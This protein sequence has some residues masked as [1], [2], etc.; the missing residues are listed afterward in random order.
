MVDM[1]V[2]R[3]RVLRGAYVGAG[4]FVAGTAEGMI[5]E[6]FDT[7]D[8]GT[9]LGQVAIGLGGSIA[10]DTVFDNPDSIPNDMVEYAGYGIQGAGFANLGRAIQTGGHAGSNVVRVE[11]ESGMDQTG[12]EPEQEQDFMADV[13]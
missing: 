6:R 8:I 5:E 11:R 2:I 4:S 13:G 7:G 3:E 10:V 1:E 12:A 9:S